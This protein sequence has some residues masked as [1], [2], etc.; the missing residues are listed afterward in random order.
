MY[1]C[2]G[3]VMNRP[4]VPMPGSGQVFRPIVPMP[5]SGQVKRHI[6]PLRVQSKPI[7]TMPAI[8]ATANQNEV[9]RSSRLLEKSTKQSQ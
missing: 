1:G 6:V 7:A 8:K 9:Q 3:Q 5:G 2:D 4:I